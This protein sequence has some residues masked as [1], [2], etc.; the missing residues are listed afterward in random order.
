MG[1]PKRFNYPCR[2]QTRRQRLVLPLSY[3]IEKPFQNWTRETS[4][5]I[6]TAMLYVDY[7][8]PMERLR[9]ELDRICRASSNWDGDVISLQVT[10]IT[11]RVAQVRCLASARSAPWAPRLPTRNSST[12]SSSTA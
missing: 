9:A 8:A 4:R 10:D 12:S 5:L 11:D 7:E 6:G 2:V 3:F 1:V